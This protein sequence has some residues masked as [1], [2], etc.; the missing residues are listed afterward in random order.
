MNI[1]Q[2]ENI[3]ALYEINK[4]KEVAKK[5]AAY[6]KNKFPFLGIPSPLRTELNQELQKQFGTVNIL[7]IEPLANALWNLPEREYQYLAMFL[8]AKVKE[9]LTPSHI[10]FV[11]DLIRDKSWWDT[12]DMLAPNFIGQIL[13]NYPELQDEYIPV[14][15]ESNNI[16]MNRTAILFQL[17][18][19]EDTNF[20]LLKSIVDQLKNKNDFFVKK[21]IGWALREYSKTDSEQV[22]RYIKQAKLQPLS[23]KEGM[24][25]I[26]K[27]KKQL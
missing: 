18:Y 22:E 21:A 8:I 5:M 20:V 4:N 11:L 16:W 25:I 26:L 14:W 15:L 12:I 6:M 9:E 7:E 2:I 17:K 27:N 24:K 19:K 1:E 23:E 13:K 10:E 3:K